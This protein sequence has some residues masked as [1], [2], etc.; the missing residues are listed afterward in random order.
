MRRRGSAAP[1]VTLRSRGSTSTSLMGCIAGRCLIAAGRS[2]ARTDRCGRDHSAI[3]FQ[4][5]EDGMQTVGVS[6]KLIAAVVTA[7][8]T[9]V[10]GQAVLD[11]PPLVVVIGQAVLVAAAAFAA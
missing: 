10:L 8:V 4:S 5:Q 9:Y 7:V 11:L 1:M 6:P 3:G 2:L